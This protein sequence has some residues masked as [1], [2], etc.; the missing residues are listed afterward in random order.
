MRQDFLR[1]SQLVISLVELRSKLV[2]K[3]LNPNMKLS[4]PPDRPLLRHPVSAF[5]Q[6][7]IQS[8]FRNCPGNIQGTGGTWYDRLIVVRKNMV[9][10][11]PVPPSPIGCIVLLLLLL[12]LLVGSLQLDGLC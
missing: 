2:Q 12:L 7:P 6:H 9:D 1:M 3:R 8:I 11:L 10:I 5:T 4:D